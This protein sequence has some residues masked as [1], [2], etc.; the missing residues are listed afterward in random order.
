MATS[1]TSVADEII[2]GR[3]AAARWQMPAQPKG[4]D[5]WMPLEYTAAFDSDG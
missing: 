3:G 4:E 2:S 1:S 5:K